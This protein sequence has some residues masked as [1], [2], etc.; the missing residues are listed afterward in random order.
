MGNIL[1][2]GVVGVLTWYADLKAGGP[3][4]QTEGQPD[5]VE[6][7]DALRQRDWS[8]FEALYV[9]RSSSDRYHFLQGVTNLSEVECAW[10]TATTPQLAT[11]TMG[12]CVGWAWRHRG[13]GVG[14]TVTEAGARS[15]WRLLGRAL[16]I[17]DDLGAEADEVALAFAIRAQMAMDGDRGGLQRLLNAAATLGRSNIFTPRN[18]LLFVAPKWHGSSEEIY[19][20]AREYA[21]RPANA[22]WLALPVMAHIEVMTYQLHMS[23]DKSVQWEGRK[24]FHKSSTYGKELEHFDDAFWA[25]RDRAQ[26]QMGYAETIFAHNI[27][28][29]AFYHRS[30]YQ[31]S[32]RDRLARHLE[33]IGPNLLVQPWSYNPFERPSL[34]ALRRRA[35]LRRLRWF[36][37]N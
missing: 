20:A 31:R 9:A 32:L 8:R 3:M 12:L 24:Y 10:P 27:F 18:H 4:D 15:M 29:Y 17:A 6:G 37:S 19:A 11:I 21:H 34:A 14:S 2:R 33:A 35:G 7:V 36:A 1:F 30:V 23:D 5:V 13:Y 28:A 26:A 16:E 25:A 22:A